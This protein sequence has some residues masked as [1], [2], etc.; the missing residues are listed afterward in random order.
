MQSVLNNIKIKLK[1]LNLDITKDG[2]NILEVAK[3]RGEL[4]FL[5]IIKD[6][7]TFYDG[8]MLSFTIDYIEPAVVAHVTREVMCISKIA[9]AESFYIDKTFRRWFGEEARHVFVMEKMQENVEI[10]EGTLLS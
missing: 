3:R 4:P 6:V 2:D 7:D 1:S 9:V 5:T 10:P 8:V